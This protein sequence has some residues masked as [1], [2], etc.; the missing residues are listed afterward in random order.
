[1]SNSLTITLTQFQTLGSSEI[2]C[3][4]VANDDH[5]DASC[6]VA[7]TWGAFKDQFPTIES[8]IDQVLGED[9]FSS[10]NVSYSVDGHYIEVAESDDDL[11]SVSH[12]TVEGAE[13]VYGP[14]PAIAV[15][16]SAPAP[17]SDQVVRLRGFLNEAFEFTV[18]DLDYDNFELLKE[19]AAPHLR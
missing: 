13:F 11:T 10:L 14:T 15:G 5:A 2:H 17:L 16:A 7:K 18:G 4:Y 12:I 19:R 6:R 9:V 3:G 1:M 8:L